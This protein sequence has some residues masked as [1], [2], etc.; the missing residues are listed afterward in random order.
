MMIMIIKM[1]GSADQIAI[2]RI[3]LCAHSCVRSGILIMN[4]VIDTIDMIDMINM[5]D[6]IDVFLNSVQIAIVR[7]IRELLKRNSF[8]GF[9]QIKINCSSFRRLSSDWEG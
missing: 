1:A 8:R 3:N 7:Q 2:V 5:I 6:T 9:G 4:D